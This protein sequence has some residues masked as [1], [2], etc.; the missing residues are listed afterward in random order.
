MSAAASPPREGDEPYRSNLR[1]QQRRPDRD[2]T[3]DRKPH[4]P[5]DAAG[6]RHHI[7]IPNHA[8]LRVGTLAGILAD[9]AEHFSVSRE[10]LLDQL[11]G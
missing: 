9:V 10:Q 7:T 1:R 2:H 4:A 5:R 3:A 6:R 11:F 8:P